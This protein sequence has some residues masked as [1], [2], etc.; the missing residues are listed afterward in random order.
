MDGTLL[1]PDGRISP[2]A[3][4]VL[5]ALAERKVRMLLASGRMAA[6]ITPYIREL[7][8]AMDVIAY[9][10]SELSEWRGDGSDGWSVSLST[11]VSEYTRDQVFALCR[12]GGHFLNVYSAG[13]LYGYHPR[14]D[15]RHADFYSGHTQAVYAAKVDSLAALPKA[16]IQKLLV[17]ETPE[18]RNRLYEAWE[19]GLRTHCQVL[20][21]NPEYLEFVA[22]GTSKGTTMAFWLEKNG[23]SPSELVA[24]GDA[25]N[26]LDL[27]RLAG[28]GIGMRN[29]TP[30]LRA[31][32]HRFSSWSNAEDGVARELERI[33]SL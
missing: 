10:G 31:A 18:L 27:L 26:D 4:K 30:G 28:L 3:A 29:S 24:F 15:F 1:D 8:L 23:F 13:K 6:R 19:P 17:V 32:F 21:S 2:A 14:G 7:G 33:F 12:D 22:S 25:E 11:T 16:D 5:G 9:N 20:K